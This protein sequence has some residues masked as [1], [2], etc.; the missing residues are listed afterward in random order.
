MSDPAGPGDPPGVPPGGRRRKAKGEPAADG[1]RKPPSRRLRKPRDAASAGNDDDTAVSPPAELGGDAASSVVEPSGET[2]APDPDEAPRDPGAGIAG[3]GD[4]GP[5]GHAYAAD[6]TEPV[7]AGEPAARPEA[8]GRDA[9]SG[10]D[11][12]VAVITGAPRDPGGK[13][14]GVGGT[15]PS[16]HADA[17][18]VAEPAPPGQPTAPPETDGRDAASGDDTRVAVITGATGGLGRWVAL[19]LAEAG[20]RTVLVARDPDRA[21]DTMDW[22]R[23]RV[24]DARLEL[25]M[26][27]MAD[28]GAV[29]SAAAAILERFPAVDLLVNNAGLVS[30][31]RAVTVDGFERTVAVNLLAPMLLSRLLMPALERTAAAR[32]EARVVNVGSSS[33]DRASIDPARPLSDGRRWSLIGSYSRSKLALLM[34]SFAQARR[35]ADAG[36]SVNVVHPGVVAT[37]LIRTGGAKEWGWRL[38]SRFSLTE[39]QGA[40]TPL[41]AALDPSLVGLSGAYL[42]RRRP[43]SPNRLAMDP[44]KCDAVLSAVEAALEPWP[45]R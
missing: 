38:L 42:K 14:A 17:A 23:R 44:D 45:V 41:F 9:A 34:A 16:G 8:G 25:V 27:D 5:S 10:D 43:V 21:R 3:V 2:E 15:G 1:T 31:R 35:V 37:G 39:A 33:S 18:D 32:G 40:D 26:A 7:P 19:G 24:P 28:L 12:R 4:T 36:V 20:M 30:E 22:I 29:A 6:V 13:I 11:T